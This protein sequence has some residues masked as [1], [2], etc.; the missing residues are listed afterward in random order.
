MKT[1]ED[2]KTL[3]EKA[4]ERFIAAMKKLQELGAGTVTDQAS[5]NYMYVPGNVNLNSPMAVDD[6]GAYII[7]RRRGHKA[8]LRKHC[9]GKFSKK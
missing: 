9:L 6:F 1:K 4:R 7:G 8:Y 3:I 5:R 2:E